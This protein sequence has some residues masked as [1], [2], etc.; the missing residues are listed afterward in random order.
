MTIRAKAIG[1]RKVFN[2]TINLI[3]KHNQRFFSYLSAF[4]AGMLILICGGNFFVMFVGWEAIG[5]VSYLLINF[6]FTRIQSN[7]A[8]MLAFTMNRGGDMLMSIGFF[9]VFSIFGSLN[10]SEVFSLVP[11]LNEVAITIIALLLLGGALA[12]SANIPLHSWLPGSMEA[13]TYLNLFLFLWIQF[14]LQNWLY[15]F[16]PDLSIFYCFSIPILPESRL[17]DS[18]GRFRSPK[19]TELKPIIPLSKEVM[20]PLIGNLL[21]DGSLQISK[22]GVDGLPKPNSNANFVMT[23]K[24]KEYVYHLWQNIYFTICTKTVPSPWPN[25]KTGLPTT[26][27]HFKSRA[28]PSLTL[29][30]SQW[31]KWSENKKGFIKIVPL[32]IEELLSPVG[33]ALWIMD[34]GFKYGNGIG[35][36]TESFTL[37]EV[38][39]LK[40]VL[41][42][43]FGLT[44]TIQ[45]RNTSGGTLGYRLY[46]SSK[47]R[48][49]LLSLVRFCLIPSMK[50]KLGL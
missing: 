24:N 1:R 37:A 25:P 27:Y 26:Q 30:H 11:Y 6:Y 19:Q 21:G 20:D 48:D 31:Y 8:A 34:D 2:C 35:L 38:E 41:E 42:F 23:L 46:I 5:V 28:L 3:A 50:Y 45:I 43:K 4:T 15:L 13:P 29:L 9:A 39:L 18:K 44:V 32:N 49:K 17:R 7:K 14:I 16:Y 33:L 47:S 36:C 12:K 40:K 10:Y 22:K